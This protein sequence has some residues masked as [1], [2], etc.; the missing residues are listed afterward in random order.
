MCAIRALKFMGLRVLETLYTL[1]CAY[2][3]FSNYLKLSFVFNMCVY[4][5]INLLIITFLILFTCL[6]DSVCVNVEG[7]RK[8]TW[9]GY[10]SLIPQVFKI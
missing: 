6:R 1:H 3:G 9:K 10:Q 5:L 2:L 7:T 4:N 8:K